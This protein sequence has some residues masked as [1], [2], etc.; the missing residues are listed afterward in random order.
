MYLSD[1]YINNLTNEVDVVE[2]TS[3]SLKA[4]ISRDVRK[5]TL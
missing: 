3:S 2:H 1:Y 4:Y 5:A